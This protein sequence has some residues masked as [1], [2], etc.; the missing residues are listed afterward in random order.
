MRSRIRLHFPDTDISSR[1]SAFFYVADFSERT[2]SAR[3]VEVHQTLPFCPLNP[4]KPMDCVKIENEKSIS[5]DF[6][7]FSDDQ[8]KDCD[9]KLIEHCEVCFFPTI[10]N[11]ESWVALMEIKDC[12]S[13]NISRYKE[14]VIEQIVSTANIYRSKNI[15]T[16]HKVYGIVAMPKCKVSFNDTIFGMP[17]NYMEL[18]K[19]HNILFL[20]TNHVRIV[21]DTAIKCN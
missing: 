16:S 18:K 15:I 14:K 4:E 8:F 6:N 21:S 5:I 12:K 3:K 1:E 19:K 17:P 10:N 7:I 9:G 11:H 20:A 13:K 2:R